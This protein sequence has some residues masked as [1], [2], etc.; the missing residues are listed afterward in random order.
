MKLVILD[1]HTLNPGDL[2]WKEVEALAETT[3]Y[4]RTSPAELAA[5]LAEAEAVLTNKAALPAAAFEAAP[6][7][8]YVGVT[9]TG[10]NMVDLEAAKHRGVT[11]TNVPGYST[12]SVAQLVFALLLE[13]THHVGHHA[14]R[15]AEGAWSA[16][17]DFCFWDF[18]LIEL[19]GKSIGLVGFGQ[20]AQAVGRIAHAFGMKVLVHTRTAKPWSEYPVTF[21]GLPALLESSDVVSLHCPLTPQ[22]QGLISWDNLKRMKRSA[23]LVNTARGGLLNDADVARA[24]QEGI[25]AHAAVDVLSAEPPPADHP[26]LSAPRCLVVPH[27]AW[28][29][30]A[31]RERLMH[32]TAENLRAFLAGKPRNVVSN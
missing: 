1:G 23:I 19:A 7:L 9:A 2:S 6:K 17:P 4:P 25:I 22:T 20:T 18:P 26:L 15:V 28:A 31:A 21:L 10:Y 11:V 14:R 24:L 12:D 8:R 16:S 27:I 32:Q 29:S 13:V 30:F 5:R 3:F